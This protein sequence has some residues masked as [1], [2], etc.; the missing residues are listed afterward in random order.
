MTPLQLS[1]AVDTV[2][3]GYHDARL[4]LLLIERG[5]DPFKGKWALPGG[6][7]RE[8]ENLEQ[9]ATR[10]LHEE[11]GVEAVYLEQLYTFGEP[12]RDPRGRVVSVAYYALV[13]TAGHDIQAGTD[14]SKAR[15]FPVDELPP[16]A[17]DHREIVTHA[18]ERVRAKVQYEP[19]AF[20]LLPV[21]FTLHDLQA[22]FEA[23]LGRV[24][25]KRNFRKKMLAYGFLKEGR[26]LRNVKFRSPSLY[27]F[28]RAKYERM[29]KRGEPFSL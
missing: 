25:D 18:L 14:A 21:E 15:W 26:K 9:A 12:K 7:V 5:L 17:F 22:F 8:D 19:L 11:T 20:E 6:F 27:R 23:T 3:F 1:L 4:Y 13:R 24:L 10:E 28:E 29:R 16:L 2:V